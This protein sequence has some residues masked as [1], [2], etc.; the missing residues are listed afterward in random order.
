M[1]DYKDNLLSTDN[2][3]WMEHCTLE[4]IKCPD[5]LKPIT[6]STVHTKENVAVLYKL[7]QA[8]SSVDKG[9]ASVHLRNTCKV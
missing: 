9:Q 8:H 5:P 6:G 7:C 3:V 2:I 4:R 1:S